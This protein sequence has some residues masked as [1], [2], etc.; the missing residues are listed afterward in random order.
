MVTFETKVWENDWRYILEGNYLNE[1]IN[2]CHFP[3]KKRVLFINNV[4]DKSLVEKRAAQKVAQNV[5]DAYY[6]VDDYAD[7]A[8]KHFNIT[9]AS[10]KGG[11]YYSIAE[12][13]SIYLCDTEYL[14][15]FS[16][17]SYLAKNDCNWIKNAITTFK[18]NKDIVIANA[19]WN[20]NFEEA[21]QEAFDD[22]KDFYVSYGCSDQCYLIKTD[23]FKRPIYNETHSD[24]ERYPKYGGE[25]FEKR[26]DSFLRNHKLKRITS[27]T[28]SYIHK[29]FSKNGLV[30]NNDFLRKL[31]IKQRLTK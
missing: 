19:C 30:Q 20:F 1:M 14:L 4:N 13:I 28:D 9:K 17:D 23:I 25:L 10:F 7:A 29:N 2:R 22:I 16:G 12:L 18:A 8:L 27:K 24:S 26:V 15:H 5:I 6:F 11:Y 31:Y 3:F 21:K